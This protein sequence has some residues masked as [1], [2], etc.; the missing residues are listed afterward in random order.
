[1][2]SRP[3]EV[4]LPLYSALVR[5]H[6]QPCIQLWSP[7]YKRDMDQLGQVQRRAKKMV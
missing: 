1:M 7:Q 6:L 4:K 3:S 5:P 2:P